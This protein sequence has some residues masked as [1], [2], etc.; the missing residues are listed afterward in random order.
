MADNIV[1]D[2]FTAFDSGLSE[3]TSAESNVVENSTD[4]A[5]TSENE[6]EDFFDAFEDAVEPNFDDDTGGVTP[7]IDNAKIA[8]DIS[9]ETK[10]DLFNG[11]GSEE[12]GTINQQ[13]TQ[14]DKLDPF[15]AF[16]N[17]PIE[18]QQP[19]ETPIDNVVN[20][21][22]ISTATDGEEQAAE[23]GGSGVETIQPTQIQEEENTDPL[24]AFNDIPK[25]Q[26][27]VLSNEGENIVQ[28][29]LICPDSQE[30]NENIN[31]SDDFLF[32]GFGTGETTE[33]EE[34]ATSHETSVEDV[35]RINNNGD[36]DTEHVNKNVVDSQDT[37]G[38]S[39]NIPPPSDDILSGFGS[40]EMLTQTVES[41]VNNRPSD[42]IEDTD[43]EEK[44]VSSEED[45]PSSN[46]ENLDT[47]DI[48]PPILTDLE[49]ISALDGMPWTPG[50]TI[51][52]GENGSSGSENN[53]ADLLST[54]F[55]SLG[56][57]DVPSST[58]D[59]NNIGEIPLDDIHE[60]VEPTIVDCD[61]DASNVDVGV[62]CSNTKGEL[63]G[64]HHNDAD[65]KWDFQIAKY[66]SSNL[67][68]GEPKT[69]ED[70]SA[71]GPPNQTEGSARVEDNNFQTLIDGV[72][73]ENN[74][75]LT[76]AAAEA[77]T[78]DFGSFDTPLAP[79]T[80]DT[81][82]IEN[83]ENAIHKSMDNIGDSLEQNAVHS[84][85]GPSVDD[86][87]GLAKSVDDLSEGLE[88][89]LPVQN[90]SVEAAKSRS[91]S[92][93]FAGFA[94]ST[95]VDVDT[96]LTEAVVDL[97]VQDDDFRNGQERTATSEEEPAAIQTQTSFVTKDTAT[98]ESNG[99]DKMGE[100]GSDGEGNGQVQPSPNKPLVS[101]E[102]IKALDDIGTE[103]APE[104]QPPDPLTQPSAVEN[105][106]DDEGFGDFET[107]SETLG[108][109]AIETEIPDDG[110]DDFGDFEA[111][112]ETPDINAIEP[113][114]NPTHDEDGFGQFEAI[115]EPPVVEMDQEAPEDIPEI[116]CPANEDDFGDFGGTP[117]EAQSS[118]EGTE[119]KH[120]QNDVP[121]TAEDEWSQ[122]LAAV[123]SAENDDD[124]FGDF[125]EFDTPFK[126]AA[127]VESSNE[128]T[129]NVESSAEQPTSTNATAFEDEDEFGNFGDFDAFE[130][131]PT[132]DSISPEG[133]E[134]PAVATTPKE[135]V[136]EIQPTVVTSTE[137]DDEFG[138]FGEFDAFEDA[139]HEEASSPEIDTSTTESTVVT[140]PV[141]ESAPKPTMLVLNESVRL[142]FQNVFVSETPVDQESREKGTCAD[143]PFNV[144]IS[145]IVVSMTILSSFPRELCFCCSS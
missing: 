34:A 89:E 41:S 76:A 35:K 107:I 139:P 24:S 87:G 78:V 12:G 123:S 130:D 99:T 44:V 112:S 109:T 125:G 72:A 20:E 27:L 114:A 57:Q 51:G 106:A 97:S 124:E 17:V 135:E 23:V 3:Y 132:Q 118:N 52:E 74:M 92:D 21:P 143:L 129:P 85:A 110:D 83:D 103:E 77:A 66:D 136:Q 134:Q 61:I 49:D 58:D 126:E 31:T 133:N 69:L 40:A 7:S 15:S 145:K 93:D 68:E 42:F 19:I 59:N 22:M 75:G 102:I 82:Q 100:S 79:D 98:S 88:E 86:V 108:N 8:E 105:F 96:A 13:S 9:M 55:D 36:E 70:N 94:S 60:T 62:P 56:V 142:M 119:V 141:T 39:S 43:L 80:N 18:P 48:L 6:N 113:I 121:P 25:E 117:V 63:N 38:S 2:D 11:T 144:P 28:P 30:G 101:K 16:N 50:S 65:T 116:E 10:V 33:P 64:I 140:T 95:N 122:P 73:G 26:D 127:L 81:G 4:G 90:D 53:G 115:S 46:N 67:A 45:T 14:E 47:M 5:D 104:E 54:A 138:D 84:K 91:S 1:D 32:S 128:E 137:D 37:E 120:E 29:N 131:A 71:E 111:I